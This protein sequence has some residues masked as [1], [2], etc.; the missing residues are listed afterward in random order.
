MHLCDNI[1]DEN[2]EKFCKLK[3]YDGILNL[4]FCHEHEVVKHRKTSLMFKS[5]FLAKLNSMLLNDRSQKVLNN[6]NKYLINNIDELFE[7]H[8]RCKKS[9]TK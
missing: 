6:I 8:M 5:T 1:N 9:L 3:S 2:R 4:R 7:D